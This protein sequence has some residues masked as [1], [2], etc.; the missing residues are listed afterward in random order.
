MVRGVVRPGRG[1]GVVLDGEDRQPLVPHAFDAVVVEVDVRDF[2][3]R[4]QA[5]GLDG[6]AV[7]VRGDLDRAASAR[8]LTG[9]LP[10]RW[11]KRSL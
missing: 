11:P 3:F 6:E 5:V 9:W 2:D 8:S 1:F 7:V 10:P 4:R